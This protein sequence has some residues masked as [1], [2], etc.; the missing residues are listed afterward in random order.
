MKS[1]EYTIQ[2]AQGIHARPAGLLIKKLKE[3]SAVP[4]LTKD[5]KSADPRKMFALMGLG[6]KCG[7]TITL[8]FDGYDESAAAKALAVFLKENL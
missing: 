2:D 5:G 8:S 3:F 6:I 4:T 7:D 1:I